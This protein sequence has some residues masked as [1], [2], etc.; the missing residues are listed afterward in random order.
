M[1]APASTIF[2]PGARIVQQP[3]QRR[4]DWFEDQ[5]GR[6]WYATVEIKT[7][8][9]TGGLYPADG[10]IAP[11]TPEWCKGRLIP[12]QKYLLITRVAGRVEKVKVDYDQWITDYLQRMDEW[13]AELRDMAGHSAGSGQQ[14]AAWIAKPPKEVLDVVG[15]GPQ[16]KIPLKLIQAMAKGNKWALGLS[17]VVPDWAL[18]V[19]D[20]WRDMQRTSASILADDA[21]EF[22]DAAEDEE[23]VLSAIEDDADPDAVGSQSG[24]PVPVKKPAPKTKGVAFPKGT[25]VNWEKSK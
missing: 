13:R 23:E 6:V 3:D 17:N 7:G 25:A 19:L 20:E 12:D 14:A 4:D 5:H 9:P 1:T 16:Q 8:H 15:Y 24:R 10:W 21:E 11:T 18:P 2:N 22:P